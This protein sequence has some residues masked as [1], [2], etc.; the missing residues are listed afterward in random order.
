MEL[1]I[2][3]KCLPLLEGFSGNF[4][5]QYFFSN[6]YNLFIL[7]F[8]LN[9]SV[10]LK[11]GK[12]QFPSIDGP[13]FSKLVRTVTGIVFKEA[14]QLVRIIILSL[15]ASLAHHMSQS[16][17]T[18]S[19]MWSNMTNSNNFL[20]YSY[21]LRLSALEGDEWRQNAA[22]KYRQL[23]VSAAVELPVHRMKWSR[24]QWWGWREI[25]QLFWCSSSSLLVTTSSLLVL[26]VME[27]AVMRFP[28]E[29]GGDK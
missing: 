19:L 24:E 4:Y 14:C 9:A 3:F 20:D 15:C 16:I 29:T 5:I 18:M 22:I 21:V 10:I 7:W 12:C 13:I 2:S 27:V 28:M 23:S 25:L 1:S 11:S 6:F 17:H 8:P 26:L